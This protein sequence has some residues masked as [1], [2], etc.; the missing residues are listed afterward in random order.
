M[1]LKVRL[2]AETGCLDDRDTRFHLRR[3]GDSNPRGREPNTLSKSPCARPAAVGDVL[4]CASAPLVLADG[5]RRTGANE[6]GTE[7]AR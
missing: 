6:T 7:T 5:D 3:M 2:N 1:R 4:T